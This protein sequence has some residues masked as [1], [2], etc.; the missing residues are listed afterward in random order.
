MHE[1]LTSLA[2]HGRKLSF[3]IMCNDGIIDVLHGRFTF[4][5]RQGYVASPNSGAV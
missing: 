5:G 4:Q 2:L 3:L 1:L